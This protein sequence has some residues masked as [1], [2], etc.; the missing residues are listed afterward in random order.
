[1][2]GIVL[3]KR[4]VIDSL[5]R[6]FKLSDRKNLFLEAGSALDADALEGAVTHFEKE[7]RITIINEGLLAYLSFDEKTILA[8]HIYSLLKS[9]G[10][11][12]ITPDIIWPSDVGHN[13]KD[14]YLKGVQTL[15]RS[16]VEKNRFRDEKEA[17]LFFEELGFLVERYP[18]SDVY[19][20]LVSV[21]RL[22][23]TREEM[24]RIIGSSVA[25]VLCI[26]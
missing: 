18:F 12:W 6:E 26:R 22:G 8:K 5:K 21:Q 2:S 15:T 17:R 10:G 13:E 14:N 1:M 9:F 4:R 16:N 25:F 24:E 11:V 19:D 3:I 7:K 23:Q 20:H